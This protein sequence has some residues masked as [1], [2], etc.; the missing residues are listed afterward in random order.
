MNLEKSRKEI[1][2]FVIYLLLGVS[3]FVSF[4]NVGNGRAET[5]LGLANQLLA[6]IFVEDYFG[7]TA[8][9]IPCLF[10]YLAYLSYTGK[11]LEFL[12]TLLLTA[13]F[14]N[15][16]F[17]VN[18]FLM[19]FNLFWNSF[20]A[21]Y[22]PR[23]LHTMLVSKLGREGISVGILS[24]FVELAYVCF[25]LGF[26]WFFMGE[27]YK[28]KAIAFSKRIYAFVS[29]YLKLVRDD[30]E[31]GEELFRRLKREEIKAMG[32]SRKTLFKKVDLGFREVSAEK[33]DFFSESL[34]EEQKMAP[35]KGGLEDPLSNENEEEKLSSEEIISMRD[36]FEDSKNRLNEEVI[37]FPQISLEAESRRNLMQ[38]EEDFF[39]EAVE[40]DLEE[41]LE[42]EEDFY[43]GEMPWSMVMNEAGDD[44]SLAL[45]DK[46]WLNKTEKVNA[47]NSKEVL[48][49]NAKQLEETLK[50]FGIGSRVENVLEGPVVTQYQISIDAGIKVNKV[51][52]LSDN[53]ALALSAS[54]VRVSFVPE[55][56]F[57]GIEIPN[58]KRETVSLQ[59]LVSGSTFKENSYNLPFALGKSIVGEEVVKDFSE[60]PHL[61]IAGSTG[62]GKSVCVNSVITSMLLASSPEELRF[63]M[64]DPKM[65]ELTIYNDIPHLLTPVIT[66]HKKAS[67]ILKWVI[68]EMEKR[69]RLL[70]L[71]R[72]RNIK[73]YNEAAK[74]SGFYK[75]MPYIVVVIDEFADLMLVARKEIEDSISRLAAMSRAVGIH[76]LLATQ[77]PSV[78][79]I[80]G[81]IKANFPS[82]IAFQ[83]SSKIDSRT[84]LDESG[85]EQLLGKGDMLYS[86]PKG[87]GL[88]RIQCCFLSDGEI[89]NIVKDLKKKGAMRDLAAEAFEEYAEQGAAAEDSDELYDEALEII[90]RNQ[91]ASI[92]FLQRKLKIGYNR[93]ARI[94]EEMEERGV[95]SSEGDLKARKILVNR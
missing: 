19:N 92:S 13:S 48:T 4:L 54:S 65:V 16:F 85:A 72:V 67:K 17:S 63:V 23:L 10:F 14:F 86:D 64:I 52:S 22:F 2:S 11:K 69:Y 49:R 83:V 90:M 59:D 3:F 88:Q 81:V 93:A 25:A 6:R 89:Q 30:F 44:Q 38:E 74:T 1:F 34:K 35:F 91:K 82:R 12:H 8:F 95:V 40:E 68:V 42:M 76:L 84:I 21:G 26:F 5:F 51:F 80:T 9:L 28:K 36:V 39:S 18:V 70:E 71:T 75:T 31:M 66:E 27:A 57:L 77:R 60:M 53:L 61:L 15:L 29:R 33:E 20:Y 73:A 78:D 43:E 37:D 79:V 50:N 7:L 87:S 47:R 24:V 56:G 46:K 32:I 62:S 41:P 94:M 55:K 58:E 45:G